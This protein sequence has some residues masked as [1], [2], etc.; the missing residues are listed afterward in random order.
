MSR[1][2]IHHLVSMHG[3]SRVVLAVVLVA[4][5]VPAGIAGARPQAQAIGVPETVRVSVT[6]DEAQANDRSQDF[7]MSSDGRYVAFMSYA[8]N[9][10]PGDTNG[11][12]DVF[13][14]D[15]ELGTTER[16]SVSS[17]EVQGNDYSAVC[18]ISANGKYVAFS[19]YASNLVPGDTNALPDIFVRDLEAGTT[20]RVSVKSDGTQ[21]NGVSAT[22]S[23]NWN[24]TL[25]T[26]ASDATNLVTTG[27]ADTNG[28]RDVFVHDM[29]T[30]ETRLESRD[31]AG[32][33][34]NGA[35]A[36]PMFSGNG[37]YVVFESDATNLV[38][39]DTNG[40]TDVFTRIPGGTTARVSVG[41]GSPGAQSNGASTH[42]CV[43][44]DGRYVTFW[45]Y[46]TSFVLG[47]TNGIYDLFLR[48]TTD[49]TTERVNVSS[50]EVQANDDAFTAVTSLYSYVTGDGRYVAFPSGA[51]NLVTGDTNG[52]DDVFLRDRT[53]GTTE[54]VS[55]TTAG[56]QA[57]NNSGQ[58]GMAV[59]SDGRYVAFQSDAT[60]MVSGDTNA[61]SDVFVRDRFGDPDP[62][63]EVEGD[64]RFE[65]AIEAS[66]LAYPDGLSKTGSRI[67]ILATG[68]N[69][70]DALGGVALAGVVDSPILLVDTH[71]I[72]AAVIAEITRL[73][74]L[75]AIILGGTSAVGQEVQ[76]A[77]EA[78]F[79]P[80]N[81]MRLDGPDRYATAN[82]I[83]KLVIDS[84][85]PEWDGRVYVATGGNFPDALAA[86]PAAARK[87]WPILLANPAS[88]LSDATKDI[89]ADPTN[90]VTQAVILG[91]TGAV[92]SSVQSYLVSEVGADPNVYRINGSNRYETA[93]RVAEDSVAEALLGWDLVGITTGEKYPDALAGGVLQAKMGSVMLLTPSASLDPFAQ[94]AIT[95]NRG[96]I[97]QVT[98]FGG[99]GAISQ[100]VRD[101]VLAAA[102]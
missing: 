98:F 73:D 31:S 71:E 65:T 29:A 67:V 69:W 9:L 23:L 90:P 19:S 40:V 51:T 17:D 93:V 44:A 4:A 18:R 102:E 86:A 33:L 57:T 79:G 83:A 41:N 10:V 6:N 11:Q 91:G 66:R 16:A 63:I 38:T 74:P 8:T 14:R 15:T 49:N 70:P 87:G 68:R 72:P 22:P 56:A 85:G 99:P 35:S 55:V 61:K 46:S 47:D 60:D 81:V 89:I 94:A 13:V 24:G 50:G 58:F 42:P 100:A 59:S 80:T 1:G 96:D 5:L 32:V 52:C 97:D 30:G 77:L 34:G 78:G 53:N 7:S 25:V 43:S 27:S 95:A 37:T 48:D 92:P 21:A 26:F 88:G 62:A 75:H 45:S 84:S 101:A 39:G 76:D 64:D 2:S 3:A 54:R 82:E 12:V 28:V 20:E 36:N